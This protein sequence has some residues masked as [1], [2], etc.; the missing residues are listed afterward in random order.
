[1][2]IYTLP[3]HTLYMH[4][5]DNIIIILL[6]NHSVPALNRT[7][8]VVGVNHHREL[9]QQKSVPKMLDDNVYVLR[10]QVNHKDIMHA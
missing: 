6:Q 4:N 9:V 10:K 5:N 3:V 7:Q 1:M 2:R 8:S